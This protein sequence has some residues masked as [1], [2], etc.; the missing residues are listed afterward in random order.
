M[1]EDNNWLRYD[2]YDNCSGT[3]TRI[4]GKELRNDVLNTMRR[5]NSP[6]ILDFANVKA[7]SSSF[8]DEFVSKLIVEM[9][10]LEFNKLVKIENMNDF[11]AHLFER[12][13]FMRMHQEWENKTRDV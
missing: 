5:A 13:T 3:G 6:I 8:I 11:V 10:I 12:S 4:A 9:G 1:L 2:V 7:C